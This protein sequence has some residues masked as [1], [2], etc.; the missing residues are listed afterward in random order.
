MLGRRLH[1]S[2]PLPHRS[3]LLQRSYDLMC[4]LQLGITFSIAQAGLVRLPGRVGPGP[5]DAAVLYAAAS[6]AAWYHCTHFPFIII[7]LLRL[8]GGGGKAAEPKSLGAAALFACVIILL[9]AGGRLRPPA[10]CRFLRGDHAALPTGCAGGR[11]L[12]FRFQVE[13]GRSGEHSGAVTVAAIC[14]P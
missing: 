4:E 8:E 2:Y 14:P 6:D 7:T 9:P 13:R 12:G 3:C 10:R 1:P 11:V 5:V